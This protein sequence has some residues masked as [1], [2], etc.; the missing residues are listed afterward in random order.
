M[1]LGPGAGGGLCW[2]VKLGSGDRV[3]PSQVWGEGPWDWI[4]ASGHGPAWG[5]PGALR[6]RQVGVGHELV[7]HQ[8]H[9]P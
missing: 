2:V 6:A 1:S 4:R 8:V 9:L 3:F 7:D 5:Q